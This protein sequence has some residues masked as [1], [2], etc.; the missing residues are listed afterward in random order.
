MK[1]LLI[2]Q[3]LGT[4]EA[5]V[6]NLPIGLTYI[7]AALKNHEVKIFDPNL[8]SLST[9]MLELKKELLIFK[10]DIAGISIRNIDTTNFRNKHV[11][12]NTVEPMARM[13]KKIRPEL[14][15]MAG[16]SG[17][18]MFAEIIMEKVPELDFGVFLEGEK[19]VPELLSHMDDP[20]SVKGIFIR[21][22]KSACLYWREAITRV[23]S[24][25]CS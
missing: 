11:Y 15:I 21:E 12:F 20:G 14:K 6:P 18:S 7:A 10:P 24:N 4:R 17:F 22:K 2:Q 16:G 9:A 8:Y 23:F 25:P 3:D 5:D 19:T 13:I 1:V